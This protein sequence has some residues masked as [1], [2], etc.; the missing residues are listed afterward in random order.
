MSNIIASLL[1]LWKP[2]SSTLQALW[3]ERWGIVF[4]GISITF[5]LRKR[6]H[7]IFK[8][9][10]S[11]VVI[12]CLIASFFSGYYSGELAQILRSVSLGSCVAMFSFLLYLETRIDFFTPLKWMGWIQLAAILISKEP[13]TEVWIMHNPS[14]ASVFVVL[15]TGVHPLSLL[16]VL[17]THSWTGF[18]SWLI[19]SWW[20]YRRFI[21]IILPIAIIVALMAALDWHVPDNGR[22]HIWTE[23]FNFFKS[24]SLL[25]QAFGVGPGTTR[26]Y[27]PMTMYHG[28]SATV[29]YVLAHNDWLQFLIEYGVV[30]AVLGTFAVVR[31]LT[32]S[33]HTGTLLAFGAA[34]LSNFPCHYAAT[35]LVAWAIIGKVN[36]QGTG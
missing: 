6:I 1:T 20:L 23:Y 2:T 15:A 31:L 21:P 9:L 12:D 10:L 32:E 4:L 13:R 25:H 33:K 16:A 7:W 18:F 26:V 8:L 11:Y 27:L 36:N 29:V 17:W 35:M 3:I 14:M 22:F 5:I 28:E 34:M 30:G 19:G 24:Q